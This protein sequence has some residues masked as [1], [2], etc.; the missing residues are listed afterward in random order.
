V[1][2]PIDLD[3]ARANLRDHLADLFDDKQSAKRVAYDA[4]LNIKSLN[5]EG[6]STNQWQAIWQEAEKQG[7]VGA[8]I[9]VAKKDYGNNR[10]FKELYSTYQVALKQKIT[11]AQPSRTLPI[12]NTAPTTITVT[13][14]GDFDS[15]QDAERQLLEQYLIGLLSLKGPDIVITKIRRGSVVLSIKLPRNKV[16]DL[17]RRLKFSE[18]EEVKVESIDLSKVN[19]RALNLSEA[20]LSDAILRM[21][22]L[23]ATDLT[24]AKLAGADLDQAIYDEKTRWPEGFDPEKHGAIL[25]ESPNRGMDEEASP[26]QDPQGPSSRLTDNPSENRPSLS[27]LDPHADYSGR[28]K[29]FDPEK[30][31]AILFESPNRGMDK[32]A[33]QDPRGR[34][35]RPANVPSEDR[36]SHSAL[37]PSSNDSG[38]ANPALGAGMTI[39]TPSE[40]WTGK[41]FWRIILLLAGSV[42]I[43]WLLYRLFL[44]VTGVIQSLV[45]QLGMPRFSVLFSLV[46]LCVLL[47][48]YWW[49]QKYHR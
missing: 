7:R 44:A 35:S 26:S 23:R 14:A 43:L 28:A 20:D 48:A 34:S 18:A 25:F 31:G 24:H 46:I 11:Q 30:R 49:H 47:V 6:S 38:R 3:I 45:V 40:V 5:F 22:D 41:R 37:D 39:E 33:S 4:G 29:G 16:D 27:A 36:P 21:A 12:K 32:E 15:F 8:L 2:E 19:L 17:Y 9:N 10:N 13:I 1:E 42:G